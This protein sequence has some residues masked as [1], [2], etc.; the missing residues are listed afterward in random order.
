MRARADSSRRPAFHTVSRRLHRPALPE[1][2]GPAHPRAACDAKPDGRGDIWAGLAAD[3]DRG[4]KP[5]WAADVSGARKSRRRKALIWRF[6]RHSSGRRFN[7]VASPVAYCRHRLRPAEGTAP[8][9]Y[10]DLANRPMPARRPSSPCGGRYGAEPV[11]GRP[12]TSVVEHRDGAALVFE[13]A[14][15]LAPEQTSFAPHGHLV[16]LRVDQG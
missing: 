6:C 9:S 8:A 15:G 4:A 2:N 16:R 12:T 13:V 11:D 5:A 3:H 10:H 1:L 7:C 14:T